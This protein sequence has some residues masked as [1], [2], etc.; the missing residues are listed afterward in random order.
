MVDHE[1]VLTVLE[2]VCLYGTLGVPRKVEEMCS[3]AIQPEAQRRA[4][5]TIN[6]Y[7]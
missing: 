2:V 7:F 1:E 4:P 3:I 5:S 6:S